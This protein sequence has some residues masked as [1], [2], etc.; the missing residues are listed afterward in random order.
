[1]IMVKMNYGAELSVEVGK[2]NPSDKNIHN[3]PLINHKID[4]YLSFVVLTDAFSM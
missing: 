1:M 4:T 2:K 3:S